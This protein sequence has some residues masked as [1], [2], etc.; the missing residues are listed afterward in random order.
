[1]PQRRA[2]SLGEEK[3]KKLTYTSIDGRLALQSFIHGCDWITRDFFLYLYHRANTFMAVPGTLE[4]IYL[5]NEWQSRAESAYWRAI[6]ACDH[7]Q[8]NRVDAAGE[9]W[10][11]IFGSEIPRTI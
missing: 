1:L 5:G 3:G 2:R 7:D 11:K 4:T 6:K 10:Q 8:Y 9:E